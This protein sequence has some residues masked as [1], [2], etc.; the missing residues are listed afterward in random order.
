MSAEARCV[1]LCA[2]VHQQCP[3]QRRVADKTA[4]VAPRPGDPRSLGAHTQ[5]IH[6]P[7]PPSRV[8]IP[9]HGRREFEIEQLRRDKKSLTHELEL[10]AQLKD[11]ELNLM[12]EMLSGF[13]EER[14]VTFQR[15]ASLEQQKETLQKEAERALELDQKLKDANAEVAELHE[16]LK[17]LE[18]EL[19]MKMEEQLASLRSTHGLLRGRASKEESE[20]GGDGCCRTQYQRVESN[21]D[22]AQNHRT[23]CI[24]AEHTSPPPLCAPNP[25]RTLTHGYMHMQTQNAKNYK[26]KSL[27]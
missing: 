13:K 4:P 26:T 15:M 11:S 5:L 14:E 24:Y 9:D 25:A 17:E 3:L 10:K 6:P 19:T 1:W 8:C 21:A 27:V 22:T 23:K 18:E 20:D 2:R 7:Q 12:R 16:A